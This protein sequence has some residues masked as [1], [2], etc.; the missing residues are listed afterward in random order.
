MEQLG[1]HR[2]DFHEICLFF[3]SKSVDKFRVSLKRL[4]GA[5]NEDR[6]TV[7]IISDRTI[8][9]IRNVTDRTVEK[10]KTHI[11]FLIPIFR[12]GPG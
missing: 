2:K 1:Y 5:L 10:I 8:L 11:L 7:M 4:G 9:A 12:G 3:F 6:C